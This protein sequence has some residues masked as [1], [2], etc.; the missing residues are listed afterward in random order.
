LRWPRDTLFP[1]ELALTSPTRD[2]RSVG[3]VRS[4]TETTQF[5]SFY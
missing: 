2:G 4:R 3:I 5:S 1:Q